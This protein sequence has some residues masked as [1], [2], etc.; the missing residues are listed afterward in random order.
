MPEPFLDCPLQGC[1]SPHM[2]VAL[3]APGEGKLGMLSTCSQ[4]LL[5][6]LPISNFVRNVVEVFEALFHLG[7]EERGNQ[8][9]MVVVLVCETEITA[10]VGCSPKGLN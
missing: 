8:E 6:I 7:F 1:L 4:P 10:W 3:F 2:P 5:S 9:W